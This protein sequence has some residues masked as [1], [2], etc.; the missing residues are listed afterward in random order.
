M[1]IPFLP[2]GAWSLGTLEMRNLGG[3]FCTIM[4]DTVLPWSKPEGWVAPDPPAGANPSWWT[5]PIPAFDRGQFEGWHRNM[6]SD[7]DGRPNFPTDRAFN[8][9]LPYLAGLCESEDAPMRTVYNGNGDWCW[10]FGTTAG[11]TERITA[12]NMMDFYID[13]YLSESTAIIVMIPERDVMKFAGRLGAEPLP[14]EDI[15][16]MPPVKF[17]TPD[18]EAGRAAIR[19][20]VEAILTKLDGLGRMNDLF[21]WYIMDEPDLEG[22]RDWATPTLLAEVRLMVRETELEVWKALDPTGFGM[23]AEEEQLARLRP[24]IISMSQAFFDDQINKKAENPAIQPKNF[25]QAGAADMYWFDYY[26][27][28]RTIAQLANEIDECQVLQDTLHTYLIPNDPPRSIRAFR[29]FRKQINPVLTPEKRGYIP[30]CNWQQAQ[31]APYRLAAATPGPTAE[32]AEPPTI[33]VEPEECPLTVNDPESITYQRSKAKLKLLDYRYL[34]WGS[35]V[36]VSDGLPY[37][38][39]PLLPDADYLN[40]VEPW[41]RE[42]AF[43]TQLR[44]RFHNRI[45]QLSSKHKKADSD[46]PLLP[47][48]P[49]P[50]PGNTPLQTLTRLQPMILFFDFTHPVRPVILGEPA[51][52]WLIVI[53]HSDLGVGPER[54]GLLFESLPAAVE[55]QPRCYWQ[56]MMWTDGELLP[57]VPSFMVPIMDDHSVP[58]LSVLPYRMRL[59]RLRQEF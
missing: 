41:L 38:A 33:K 16:V 20:F 35:V 6:A 32:A 39:Q 18:I 25:R 50:P 40:L 52:T 8:C 44:S 56:E 53:N 42:I 57:A 47:P 5:P 54:L 36:E 9:V 43:F 59:F 27:Y 11:T 3:R 46:N 26:P 7:I 45:D 17:P 15:P 31:G 34:A 48:L 58:L 1:A 49:S 51:T 2:P 55:M 19:A 24:I 14:V 22:R 28:R 30:V 13:N 29:A 37:L 21:G 4:S 10:P 23:M 12:L